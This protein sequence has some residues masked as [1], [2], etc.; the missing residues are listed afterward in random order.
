MSIEQDKS[1]KMRWPWL[2]IAL[3]VSLAVNLLIIGFLVGAVTRHMGDGGPSARSPGLGAFGAPYMLALT[4]DDRRDVLRALR[5]D[6]RDVIPDRDARR[7]MFADVVELLRAQPFDPAALETAVAQQAD[8]TVR[9][10]KRAQAAWFEV[11]SGM[12]DAERQDY[13]QT[14]EAVLQ[15]RRKK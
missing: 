10:Q 2:K 9:V 11:V 12:S 6:S 1:G 5:K 8:V 4:K 14:I 13:A 7:K 15:R 3:G